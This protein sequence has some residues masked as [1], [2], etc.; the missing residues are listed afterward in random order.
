MKRLLTSPLFYLGVYFALVVVDI[1][2]SVFLLLAY[3][4]LVETNQI[5]ATISDQ[6]ETRPREF[7]PSGLRHGKN[8]KEGL[9]IT[10]LGRRKRKVDSTEG[11]NFE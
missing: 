7:Q 11:R 8:K 1:I 9:N 6:K 5:D 10:K 4:F 2:F 3:P